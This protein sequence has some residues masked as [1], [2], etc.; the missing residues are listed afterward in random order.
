M[1]KEICIMLFIPQSDPDEN[2]VSIMIFYQL[3]A[4]LFTGTAIHVNGEGR[5]SQRA[6]RRIGWG[7]LY[8]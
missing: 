3:L 2:I 4:P 6:F 8:T 1:I 7:K 5:M